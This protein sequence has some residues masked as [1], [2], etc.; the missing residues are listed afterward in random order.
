MTALEGARLASLA[1]LDHNED[2][3]NANEIKDLRHEVQ[4]PMGSAGF[5]RLVFNQV[6]QEDTQR[7]RSMEGMWKGRRPPKPLDYEKLAQATPGV[8]GRMRSVSAGLDGAN[9]KALRRRFW[10][11]IVA[12]EPVLYCW[13]ALVDAREIPHA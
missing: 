1:E 6:F 12:S 7:L 13:L 10:D 5:P 8:G 11:A 3:E 4:A 2:P 9:W